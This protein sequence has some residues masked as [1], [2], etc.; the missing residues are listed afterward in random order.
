VSFPPVFLSPTTQVSQ[1]AAHTNAISMAASG[2]RSNIID[3]GVKDT[4]VAV[5]QIAIEHQARWTSGEL[6]IFRPPLIS[7]MNSLEQTYVKYQP[8]MATT[9]PTVRIRDL[10]GPKSPAG[11]GIR[12]ISSTT[13]FPSAS[14]PIIT[15]RRPATIN[16]ITRINGP[17]KTATIWFFSVVISQYNVV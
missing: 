9:S 14:V 11:K 7:R 15:V 1:I 4:R 10:S 16:E 13:L 3:L 8:E 6:A 5:K 17:S 2:I 12:P